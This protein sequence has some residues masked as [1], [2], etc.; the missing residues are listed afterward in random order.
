MKV[1]T[2][3]NGT[4]TVIN[5]NSHFEGVS[6]KPSFIMGTNFYYEPTLK[7]MDDK[8]LS[9]ALKTLALNFINNYSFPSVAPVHNTV[10]AHYVDADGNYMGYVEN[11]NGYTE[12]PSAPTN[13]LLKW[14]NGKWSKVVLV[15]KTT[16]YYR[17][18]GDTRTSPNST[19]IATPIPTDFAPSIY[20]WTGTKWSVKLSDAKSEKTNEVRQ[21][22]SQ[23][24]EASIGTLASTEA[25]S[26]TTQVAEAEAWTA[27]NTAST[28]FIDALLASRAITGK[29]ILVGKILA[30]STA[31]KTIY[32]TSLGKFQ[33][34][35]KKINTATTV[36]QVAAIKWV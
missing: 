29:A 28:P 12:V 34:L 14:V 18:V 10:I 7:M 13:E 23:S 3:V 26:F 5:G 17:G 32:A 22:Q 15:D 30:N 21:A 8:P 24:M 1:L 25:A 19:Y 4:L 20:Y 16:K 35:M 33:A 9:A 6:T 27:N 31:Y 11:T 36:S 2:Y